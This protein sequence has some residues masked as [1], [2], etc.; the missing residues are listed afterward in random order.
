MSI[1]PKC[2]KSNKDGVKFCAYC[3]NPLSQVYSQPSFNNGVP[4]S[5]YTADTTSPEKEKKKKPV[6]AIIIAVVAVIL[7]AAVAFGVIFIPDLLN[8]EDQQVQL[9]DKEK[10]KQILKE[11]TTKPI[12]DMVCKDFDSDGTVEAYAVVGKT[13][14]RKAKNPDYYEAD[15]YFVN[16]K[17]A[18]PIKENISGKSNG[19]IKT[20]DTVYISLEVCEEDSDIGYS[21]IY[22]VE[23]NQAAASDTSGLYHE[24]H[25]EGDEILAKET[26]D[27]DFVMI[28]ISPKL[29]PDVTAKALNRT[30]RKLEEAVGVYKGSFEDYNGEAGLTLTVYEEDGTYQALFEFYGLP[31]RRNT[32]TG[33]LKMNVSYDEYSDTYY[34][35]GYEWDEDSYRYG[36]IDLQGTLVDGVLSGEYPTTFSVITEDKYVEENVMDDIIGVY[37]GSYSASIERGLTLTVYEEDGAYKATFEFYNMPGMDNSKSGKYLMNVYYDSYNQSY[38]FESEEWIEKPSGYYMINLEGTLSGDVL[39]GDSPYVFSV[40]RV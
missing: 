31:G 8:K 1:C 2:G 30:E 28:D 21:Y 13:N 36:F 7:A 9:S 17:E 26:P 14:D 25:Q 37:Q 5:D 6:K 10:L 33:K 23:D 16:D 22:T 12:V 19:L 4:M 11:S 24:V 39:S 40:T 38:E 35:E 32:E 20:N 18:Q 29:M 15:I 27:S 3:G 34:F